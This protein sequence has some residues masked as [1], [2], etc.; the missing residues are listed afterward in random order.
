VAAVAQP[1]AGLVFQFGNTS[2]LSVL[3]AGAPAL[4]ALWFLALGRGTAD[5][6]LR[7][8]TFG[9]T[10]DQA[11]PGLPVSFQTLQDNL[12]N[13][14][15]DSAGTDLDW[16]PALGVSPR[17]GAWPP[18]SAGSMSEATARAVL[19]EPAALDQYLAAMSDE[20][21]QGENEGTGSDAGSLS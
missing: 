5:L 1:A 11:L 16:L 21:D 19:T 3:V 4:P 9:E 8:S 15:W 18:P 10:S 20:P 2:S 12:D 7:V 6:A 17:T 13:R 14:L